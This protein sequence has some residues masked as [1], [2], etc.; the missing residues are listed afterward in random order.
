MKIIDILWD[1][2]LKNK[3][4]L[5]IIIIDQL[6]IDK[7]KLF[8]NY[9]LELEGNLVNTILEKY[10]LY[11]EKNKPLEYILWYVEFF[12][13]RFIVNEN[14]LIPRPETEY[15][16]QSVNDFVNEN[17]QSFDLIDVWTWCWVLWLS[18]I[19][20]NSKFIKTAYLTDISPWAIE[21]A[22][23]NK[24][25]LVPSF[26]NINFYESDLLEVVFED[27]I[28]FENNVLLVWN[29]PYIPN[30]IFENEVE[31]NVKDWEPEIAFLWWNDGLDLY[32]KMFSQILS[33]KNIFSSITMFLEMTKTQVEILNEEYW[34]MLSFTEV[35]TFHFNIIILKCEFKN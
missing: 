31:A 32:R 25:I 28:K 20:F 13:N 22:K 30:E 33:H 3:K 21:V 10:K 19:Y 23:K 11:S 27:N 15:M 5:E 16:I 14:T 4:I 35:A 1:K 18:T 12:W 6:N 9:E 24:S 34:N 2:E 7:N 26:K 17:K 8:T 29:L